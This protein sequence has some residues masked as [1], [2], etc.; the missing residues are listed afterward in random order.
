MTS[1]NLCCLMQEEESKTAKKKYRITQMYR[2]RHKSILLDLLCLTRQNVDIK[3]FYPYLLSALPIRIHDYTTDI[4]TSSYPDKSRAQPIRLLV[5][6]WNPARSVRRCLR[7]LS[8]WLATSFGPVLSAWPIQ[9][10]W[11]NRSS[12]LE[13]LQ[14]IRKPRKDSLLS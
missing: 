14:L 5:D 2:Q 9:Y 7:P 1:S 4:L 12:K 13:F 8:G 11:H 3:D 6:F 10:I